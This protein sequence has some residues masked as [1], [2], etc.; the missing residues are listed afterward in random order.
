[1]YGIRS[2]QQYMPSLMQRIHG[3]TGAMDRWGAMENTYPLAVKR[4]LDADFTYLREVTRV[5]LHGYKNLTNIH[6]N[7]VQQAGRT[8]TPLSALGQ[9][10]VCMG[11]VHA[12]THVC[13]A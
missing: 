6:G 12:C 7:T 13:F 11:Y 4:N 9:Q 5:K 8:C 2:M 3:G 10:L 1:M